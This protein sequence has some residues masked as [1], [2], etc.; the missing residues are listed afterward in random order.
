MEDHKIPLEGARV[1]CP[2][3][4]TLF[5]VNHPTTDI[6]KTNWMPSLPTSAEALPPKGKKPERAP[7]R[8]DPDRTIGGNDDLDGDLSFLGAKKPA[9]EAKSFADR[10][11]PLAAPPEESDDEFGD[12]SDVDPSPRSKKPTAPF[13]DSAADGMMEVV[14]DED[15]ENE[16]DD[17]FS[18]EETHVIVDKEQVPPKK[19]RPTID[20]HQVYKRPVPDLEP[21]EPEPRSEDFAGK[22][23]VS[24]YA[25]N[26]DSALNA[27][28]PAPAFEPIMPERA[29]RASSYVGK[30]P[31]PPAPTAAQEREFLNERSFVFPNQGTQTPEIDKHQLFGETA[32]LEGQETAKKEYPQ[33]GA[34]TALKTLAPKEHARTKVEEKTASPSHPHAHEA[35]QINDPDLKRHIKGRGAKAKIVR[36][37]SRISATTIA[38]VIIVQ[39]F[40]G[41]EA[42]LKLLRPAPPA[43]QAVPQA[44]APV[45]AK[46][47]TQEL[48]DGRY[49]FL[50][51][52]PEAYALAERK[53]AS[54]LI[55]H[56]G[57]FALKCASAENKAL[58]GY[59]SG[60]PKMV[61]QAKKNLDKI[62]T[63]QRTGACLRADIYYYLEKDNP[64]YLET[65]EG[66]I[67]KYLHIMPQEKA[68]F[69]HLSGLIALKAGQTDKAKERF[70]KAYEE[71]EYFLKALRELQLLEE[72]AGVAA[73][74]TS[75][76][77]TL[78]TVE[79]GYYEKYPELR[80]AAPK[81]EAAEASDAD[82]AEED[83]PEAGEKP[84]KARSAKANA[85]TKGEASPKKKADDEDSPAPAPAQ[86]DEAPAGG[87]GGAFYTAG[88]RNLAAGNHAEAKANFEKAIKKEPK[89]PMPHLK[90]AETL[91][92]LY[93][94]DAAIHELNTAIKLKSN[95]AEA[96]KKLGVIYAG[97]SES[98]KAISNLQKYLDLA[99][100][101]KDKAEIEG[102]INELSGQ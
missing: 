98:E 28:P 80:K 11:A 67:E 18:L 33:R 65:A 24:L 19:A 72:A 23:R 9:P 57:D 97:L 62:A 27:P 88:V 93:Q 102:Y 14:D 74:S 17:E 13:D 61:M 45:A 95:L 12:L 34:R 59:K 82:T 41:K 71:D 85:K 37:L 20:P 90:L 47:N 21:L 15:L 75:Y 10:F 70:Q 38:V 39:I 50:F 46:A 76:A 52:S 22:T 1:K 55:K 63:N 4:M 31:Q 25:E 36:I 60:D 91:E 92:H 100:N 83:A 99:P 16:G 6:E 51:D 29:T 8:I 40:D 54:G 101:A 77:D 84:S 49:L 69:L 96:Y 7:R 3:C 66:L 94:T 81:K 68:D 53:F 73:E 78:K 64:K 30:A 48:V 26:P 89:N 56:K 2:N 42:L 86:A 44:V 58:W 5:W 79:E 43:E 32:D 87:G 35:S